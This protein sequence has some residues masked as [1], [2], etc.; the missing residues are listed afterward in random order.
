[1]TTRTFVHMG[2]LRLIPEA[3][4]EAAELKSQLDKVSTLEDMVASLSEQRIQHV[5]DLADAKKQKEENRKE[6]EALTKRVE[7]VEAENVAK[8]R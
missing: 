4:R 5:E 6:I 3:V 2:L 7:E 1:M 8:E